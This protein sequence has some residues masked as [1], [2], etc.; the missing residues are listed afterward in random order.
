MEII[1]DRALLDHYLKDRHIGEYF[2]IFQPRFLLLRYRPGELLTTPFSPSQYLQ[3]IINGDLLLYDMPSEDST[4]SLQTSHHDIHL[5]G[6]MELLDPD[7]A[8]FFVEARSEVLT[9]AIPLEQ[10]REVLLNDPVFLRKICL[11]LSDKLRGATEDSM[12]IGL[13][14]RLSAYIDRL[15]PGAE[16][17]GVARLAEQL[18]VS[19]RQMIRVLKAFCEEGRLVREK[20]GVY[21]VL[22][23]PGKEKR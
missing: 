12:H 18:N 22:S 8:T 23:C 4:V 16:L 7:F 5:I 19:E 1:N 6:E 10:Y 2:S 15:G 13:K 9:A 14:E 11:N 3:F 17:K 20:A 21:R